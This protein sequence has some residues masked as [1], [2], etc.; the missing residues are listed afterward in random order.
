[1]PEVR[2]PQMFVDGAFV[3]AASDATFD[4][5]NPA[6]EEVVARLAVAG[7]RDVDRAV[8]AARA[9]L[10]GPW[11]NTGPRERQRLLMRLAGL[12]LDNAEELAQL[13]T[14]EVGIPIARSRGLAM[15]SAGLLEWYAA[16]SRT[17]RGATIENNRP[18]DLISS[19]LRQPIGVVG[20]ITPWNT[21]LPMMMWKLG[22]VLATGSTLVHKPAEISSLSALRMAELCI[23]AGVP[24]GVVNVVTG[25]G[26]TGALLA[27]HRGVD[28]IAFTGSVATGQAIVRA[29]AGNLKRL[30]MELGGKSPSIVFADADLD[31]AAASVARSIF[32]NSGQVCV[33]GSRLLVQDD[34]HDEFVDRVA[35]HARALRVGDPLA[36]GTDMGPVASKAQ[37]EKVK[38]FVAGALE[39]GA[40]LTTGGGGAGQEKGYY[41]EPTVLTGVANHS[42]LAQG[43]VFGPVLGVTRFSTLDDAVALANGTD[44]GLSSYVWTTNMSTANT[45][46][47]R[48]K[49]GIVQVNTIEGLDPAVPVGGHGMSGY[50]KELGLE[51]LDEYLSTKSVWTA[52]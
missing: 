23:E 35:E 5:V 39:D 9:A 42:R 37:W 8:D 17:V 26:G 24:D 33:A 12:V 48:I 15:A 49:A 21:P 25:N 44:F 18:A 11:G 1:M 10:D 46:V 30:T 40:E 28:K 22:P 20:A 2:T 51:Q 34:V 4:S 13:D 45:M 27:E 19:T 50:G 36:D 14:A 7:E 38:D 6:T 47:R 52:R 43:E 31:R 16:L 29:S 32:D 3:D 41:V